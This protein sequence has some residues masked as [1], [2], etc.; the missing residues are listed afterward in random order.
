MIPH[1]RPAGTLVEITSPEVRIGEAQDFLDLMAT[2][3]HC[4]GAHGVILPSSAFST[5]FFDLKT[6][7]AGEIL[8]K[9]SNYGFRLAVVGDFSGMDAGPL[10]DFIRESNRGGLVMFAPSTEAALER[11]A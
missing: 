8:Q 10:R 5:D 2:L 11:L 6:G 3:R 9:S 1:H 4:H 7:L